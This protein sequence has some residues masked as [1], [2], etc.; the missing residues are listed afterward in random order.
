MN[1][2][3]P[4][5]CRGLGIS[6][7][8]AHYWAARGYVTP[9]SGPDGS[10]NPMVWT[11]LDIVAIAALAELGRHMRPEIA[12]GCIRDWVEAGHPDDGWIGVVDGRY[13]HHHSIPATAERIV[14]VRPPRDAVAL[15]AAVQVEHD[16]KPRGGHGASSTHERTSM[17]R[18][19]RENR[20]WVLT[21]K[22][23]GAIGIGPHPTVQ[24]IGVPVKEPDYVPQHLRRKRDR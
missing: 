8:Q 24:T 21:D 20:G 18:Q 11:E 10:G 22:G 16:P 19:S 23:R 15:V 17:S 5:V 12:A 4:Q 14:V 2:S 3:T 7:R 13:G 9:Q 6:Y 1:A